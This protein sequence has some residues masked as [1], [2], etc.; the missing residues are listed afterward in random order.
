MKEAKKY[1]V[2]TIGISNNVEGKILKICDY[3]ILLETGTEIISK[4]Q[5]TLLIY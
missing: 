2:M 5:F 1:D 3:K 4:Y